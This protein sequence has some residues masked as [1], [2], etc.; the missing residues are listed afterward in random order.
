M[1]SGS[2][3]GVPAWLGEGQRSVRIRTDDVVWQEL[4][5]EV[6]VFNRASSRYLRINAS[7]VILWRRLEGGA[8]LDDLVSALLDAFDIDEST[9]RRDVEAF[10]AAVREH[11]LL[12][13]G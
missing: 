10:V 9:A 7:A 3:C 1:L 12:E 8:S 11:E 13:S 5:D 2:L 4:D 6:V